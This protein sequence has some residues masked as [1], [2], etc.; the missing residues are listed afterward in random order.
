MG[1]EFG[2]TYDNFYMAMWDTKGLMFRYVNHKNV[3]GLDRVTA[4]VSY[5]STSTRQKGRVGAGNYVRQYDFLRGF[6]S[7]ACL[8][9]RF[10]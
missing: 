4:G 3:A 10:T 9:V 7:Q 6:T 5:T 8:A 1:S 2:G